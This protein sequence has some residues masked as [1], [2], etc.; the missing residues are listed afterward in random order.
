MVASSRVPFLYPEWSEAQRLR[1]GV[2]RII[3]RVLRAT[4]NAPSY[5]ISL[6]LSF[7]A[8]GLARCCI[9]YYCGRFALFY[10]LFTDSDFSGINRCRS[11]DT[12]RT[13]SAL[14]RD[15]IFFLSVGPA[16]VISKGADRPHLPMMRIVRG[17]SSG[18]GCATLIPPWYLRLLLREVHCGYSIAIQRPWTVMV[19]PWQI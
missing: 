3:L 19:P 6:P 5:I 18:S 15:C 9:S 14:L 11:T 1:S 10:R 7:F 8:C 4:D 2:P 16:R 12:T 17:T 13:D